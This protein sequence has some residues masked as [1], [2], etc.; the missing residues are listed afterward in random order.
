MTRQHHN[1]PAPASQLDDHEQWGESKTMDGLPHRHC[2]RC[3]NWFIAYFLN[4]H[5]CP[6]PELQRI[7]GSPE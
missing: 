2:R 6:V 7:F 4:L 3:G 5:F 1:N